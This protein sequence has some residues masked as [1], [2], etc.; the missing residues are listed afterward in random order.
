MTSAAEPRTAEWDC[1]GQAC[2][3]HDPFLCSDCGCLHNEAEASRIDVERL[4]RALDWWAFADLGFPPDHL[5]SLKQTE[6]RDVARKMAATLAA[7]YARQAQ[8][9]A[10]R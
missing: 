3:C 5:A 8:E 6:Q 1:D 7:E 10:E 4:A 2:R 9:A